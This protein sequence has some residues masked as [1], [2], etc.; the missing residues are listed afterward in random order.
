MSKVPGSLEVATLIAQV[1]SKEAAL[2]WLLA[3]N[4]D[5]PFNRTF[6]SDVISLF[7]RLRVPAFVVEHN[8]YQLRSYYPRYQSFLPPQ[9]RG[10]PTTIAVQ[11]R[12]STYISDYYLE[13]LRL[14]SR[15]YD[16]PL[17]VYDA[18]YDP[19]KSL[20]TEIFIKALNGTT[21]TPQ[22]LRDISYNTIAE[23]RNFLPLWAVA[24][25]TITF[26]TDSVALQGKRWLDISAGWGDRLL[27]ACALDM[28]YDGFDPNVLLK[29]AHDQMLKDFGTGKQQVD[30]RPFEEVV[31]TEAYDV[32]LTSPPYFNL[33]VYVADQAGQSIVNY[34]DQAA[35]MVDFLFK[36]IAKA[37][38][39]LKDGGYLILHLGD[40]QTIRSAEATNLFINQLPQSSWEGV[41][42]LKGEAGYYRPV[43]IWSKSNNPVKWTKSTASKS[44]VQDSTLR[45]TYPEYYAR[46]KTYEIDS[47]TYKVNRTNAAMLRQGVKLCLGEISENLGDPLIGDLLLVLMLADSGKEAT[48]RWVI[49]TYKIALPHLV[50]FDLL[51]EADLQQMDTIYK[52]IA[53]YAGDRN[54][55]L[56]LRL[57]TCVYLALQFDLTIEWYKITYRLLPNYVQYRDNIV[58]LTKES[59]GSAGSNGS[60][61]FDPLFVHSLLQE[62][63]YD[64]TDQLIN[65]REPKIPLATLQSIEY[66]YAKN[67][68]NLQDKIDQFLMQGSL[69]DDCVLVDWFSEP[70]Y[71]S[72]NWTWSQIKPTLTKALTY[73][74]V[75]KLLPSHCHV[76]LRE[77]YAFFKTVDQQTVIFDHAYDSGSIALIAMLLKLNYIPLEHMTSRVSGILDHFNYTVSNLPPTLVTLDRSTRH[78]P[79]ELRNAPIFLMTKETEYIPPYG[80][81]FYSSDYL[82]AYKRVDPLTYAYYNYK[83][84]LKIAA[85]YETQVYP[86]YPNR[87]AADDILENWF[88]ARVTSNRT[89]TAINKLAEV[90]GVDFAVDLFKQ[91]EQMLDQDVVIDIEEP[92]ALS[93][94]SVSYI[95]ENGVE[96]A[97]ISYKDYTTTLE[98]SRYQV[99]MNKGTLTELVISALTYESILGNKRQWAGSLELFQRLHDEG[100]TIEGMASPFN[101][102]LL[103]IDPNARFCS[104]FPME[105]RPFGSIG[106]FFNNDYP[107]EHVFLHPPRIV[108]FIDRM[109]QYCIA[110]KT[111]FPDCRFTMIIPPYKDT[112]YYQLLVEAGA[113][114]QEQRGL[115]YSINVKT[116]QRFE[117]R[118]EQMEVVL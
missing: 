113:T 40:T 42:G 52:N 83:L 73:S 10:R 91:L 28:Y 69:E 20:Q 110:Q 112:K 51:T 87:I 23:V 36:S 78:L 56:P 92:G 41:I 109:V 47:P 111:A 115:D 14:Q 94:A 57:V 89:D 60:L 62:R 12:S 4:F 34:P 19:S 106:S 31:L 54:S 6:Q 46:L 49:A 48:I 30:Y 61:P 71:N 118:Y 101:C 17:S 88:M 95:T 66:P 21:I 98:A 15:R 37:W 39:A 76:P 70:T 35:W 5:Y 7:E 102:Q 2:N 53:M 97:K 33:E 77:Y 105:D 84:A 107:G 65:D 63:G 75:R 82:K 38:R 104:L 58:G 67:W 72:L 93:Q 86:Y 44:Q 85:K 25:L 80:V 9:F 96:L 99:L 64:K 79:E 22:I 32:I 24:L 59:N 68:I 55:I 108:E 90:T 100:V 16:Q 114:I 116:G 18:W 11:D 3:Q 26:N 74:E 27:A 13:E 81:R 117:A 103:M 45:S 29:P 1:G 50:T 43:W 8:H